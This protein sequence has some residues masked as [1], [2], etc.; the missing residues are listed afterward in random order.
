[1]QFDDQLFRY[2]GTTELDTLSEAGLASGVERMKVDLGLES[3]RG[4]RFALWALLHT[5]GEAPDLGVAFC[6]PADRDAAR[7]LM[8]LLDQASAGA[9]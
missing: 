9:G 6:D 2:F 3:D 5:F 8:D 4:R 7:N 1:M